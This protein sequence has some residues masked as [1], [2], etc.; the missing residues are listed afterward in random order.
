MK[1]VITTAALVCANRVIGV[2]DT[3]NDAKHIN[4]DVLHIIVAAFR[5]VGE[6][7]SVPSGDIIC[8]TYFFFA[9]LEKS[10]FTSSVR[11]PLD[12]KKMT[13]K[14]DMHSYLVRCSCAF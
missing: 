10:L 13:K 5:L 12:S 14:K 4:C 6:Q 7:T 2:A 1:S 3:A 11:T 8:E 9:F